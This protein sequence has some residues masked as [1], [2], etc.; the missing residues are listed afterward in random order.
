MRRATSRRTP[1]KPDRTTAPG[2]SSMMKSTPVRFS[3]ARM[4][5]PSRPMIRPFM[6]SADS[7]T[8]D[9]VVSAAWPAARRCMHTERMLRTRRSASRLVCSSIWRI[10]LAA[11][12]LVCSS[13]SLSSRCLAL[14]AD[15]PEIRS[16]SRSSA[17]RLSARASVLRSSSARL[18]ARAASRWARSASRRA[19]S[20][21]RSGGST[22]STPAAGGACGSATAALGACVRPYST[23]AST[24]PTAISA[25]APMISMVVPPKARTPVQ[26]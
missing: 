5:R 13:T 7:W 18:R 2:V 6:S 16:S 11:S 8:T 22:S 21:L 12:C 19:M 25:A 23:A 20:P 4:L 26:T 10:R 17:W 15:M 24:R 14:A 1:S 9:T 3:S